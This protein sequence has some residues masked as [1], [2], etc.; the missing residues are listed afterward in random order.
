MP[1]I[2]PPN[3]Q[4]LR[5]QVLTQ[6]GHEGNP[7]E[8]EVAITGTLDGTPALI[9]EIL[10]GAGGAAPLI[11]LSAG[12][13]G[14]N[15]YQGICGTFFITGGVPPYTVTT[16]AGIVDMDDDGFGGTIC[17]DPDAGGVGGAGDGAFS[18]SVKFCCTFTSCVGKDF[19]CLGNE[20]TPCTTVSITCPVGGGSCGCGSCSGCEN[21]S[22]CSTDPSCNCSVDPCNRCCGICETMSSC[23]G[24]EAHG[25]QCDSRAGGIT[26]QPCQIQ[27]QNGANVT[28]TDS[29]GSSVVFEMEWSTEE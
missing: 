13:G 9:P 15:C 8:F 2:Q 5:P 3:T 27:F 10:P 18:K 24:L 14:G 19:D 26:C 23:E 11:P 21:L 22:F 28:V 1:K 7:V 12:G 4:T 29:D 16:D 6:V 20:I 25:T 17:H